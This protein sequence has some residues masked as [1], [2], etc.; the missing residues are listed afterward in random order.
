[1]NVSYLI[2]RHWTTKTLHCSC[3]K[4]I[5]LGD[6][7]WKCPTTSTW[8]IF[9]KQWLYLQFVATSKAQTNILNFDL[10]KAHLSQQSVWSVLFVN[11]ESKWRHFAPNKNILQNS[12]LNSRT[13]QWVEHIKSLTM[14]LLMTIHG[15]RLNCAIG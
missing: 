13:M 15:T 8:S 6:V 5:N 2:V 11:K 9:P 4:S 7:A 14:H 1:M 10:W 12:M 3:S